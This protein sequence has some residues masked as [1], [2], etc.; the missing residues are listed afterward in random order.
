[1]TGVAT[2]AAL[3]Q[4]RGK[5]DEAYTLVCDEF[6]SLGG[7]Y[8]K[9]IQ[10][11]LLNSPMLKRWHSPDKLKIFEGLASESLDI[12]ALLH[13]ELSAEKLQRIAKLQPEPFAA[14][15]FGQVYYGEL[16]DGTPIIVKALRPQVRQLLQ[17]DLRLLGLFSRFFVNRQYKNIDVKLDDA[18]KD[19]RRATLAETDYVKEAKFASEMYEQSRNNPQLVIPRTYLDLCTTQVIVQDYIDG[20]SCATVLEKHANQKINPSK[21]IQEQLGSDLKVQLTTLGVALL[22]GC[23]EQN[24]IMGDPHPGNIRLMTDN[25]VA[26]IDFGIS[27]ASPTNRAAFYGLIREW[28]KLYHG[29]LDIP[30]LFEQGIRMFVND[31]YRSLK[32]LTSLMPQQ[33]KD[34]GNIQQSLLKNVGGVIQE[35]F[36]GE[37]PTDDFME[38]LSQKRLLNIFNNIINKGNRLGLIMKLEDSEILRAAQTYMSTVEALGLRNEVLS[39]VFDKVV[40]AAEGAA[41]GSDRQPTTSQALEIVNGW[42]ER[43]ASKDPALFRKLLKQLMSAGAVTAKTAQEI[44]DKVAEVPER[45][46]DAIGRT[47]TQKIID[48]SEEQHA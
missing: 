10:G 5:Y 43:V 7:I 9:F 18:I 47:V 34:G 22:S 26:L 31:L 29:T 19:F 2:R 30:A 11:V 46:S 28:A 33:S 24:R 40:S 45:V 48:T 13:R 38:E 8:V 21:F 25:R 15:S 36:D 20:I 41:H 4:R 37:N 32:K 16:D 1:L 44:T 42:L 23:F 3:L 39:V 14:G 6:V 12:V 17:H 27:A 35:L